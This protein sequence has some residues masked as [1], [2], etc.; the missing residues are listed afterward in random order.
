MTVGFIEL[1]IFFLLIIVEGVLLFGN[2]SVYVKGLSKIEKYKM[3]Y[4]ILELLAFGFLAAFELTNGEGGKSSHQYQE[5][6]PTFILQI[7]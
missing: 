7:V 5:S 4:Q 2:T 6:F 3:F 1:L